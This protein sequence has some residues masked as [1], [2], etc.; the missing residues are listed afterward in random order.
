[1][2]VLE[3]TPTASPSHPGLSL[4]AGLPTRSRNH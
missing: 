4:R 2:T 3:P 1:M